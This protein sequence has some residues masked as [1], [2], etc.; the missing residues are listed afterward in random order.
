MF[1]VHRSA[2]FRAFFATL[3]L[4]GAAD[5]LAAPIDVYLYNYVGATQNEL[6]TA[7]RLVSR[8]YARSSVELRWTLPLTTHEN[9]AAQPLQ[10]V[11]MSPEMEAQ[12]A[13]TAASGEVFGTANYAA[14]R[15][16]V[17]YG[18]VTDHI[19]RF[20]ASRAVLLAAV[21]AHELGHLLLPPPAHSQSGLMS[22]HWVGRIAEVPP[23]TP[24]EIATLRAH[25]SAHVSEGVIEEF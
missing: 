18:R 19:Y 20:P 6:D 2:A 8:V 12:K 11:L 17:F 1:R 23:F 16:W 25:A 7:M 10:V 24:K 15:A 14:G 3:V 21:I 22:P 9:P 5:L 4:G 13:S